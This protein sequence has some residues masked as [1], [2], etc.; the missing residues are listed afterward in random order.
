MVLSSWQATSKT[1]RSIGLRSFFV[2][3][4]QGA[5]F[6]HVFFGMGLCTE[7]QFVEQLFIHIGC[8]RQF[9]DVLAISE[10]QFC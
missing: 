9:V 4:E 8:L 1:A 5:D 6:F 2:A 7:K 3:V 10:R